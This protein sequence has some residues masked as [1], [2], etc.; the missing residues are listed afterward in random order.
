LAAKTASVEVGGA[1]GNDFPQALE[2]KLN[3]TQEKY[4]T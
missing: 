3:Q 4:E 2:T 1:W